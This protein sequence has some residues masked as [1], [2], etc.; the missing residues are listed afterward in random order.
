MDDRFKK[1]LR[2]C[3]QV[4]PFRVRAKMK[5]DVLT[6]SIVEHLKTSNRVPFLVLATKINRVHKVRIDRT[7]YRKLIEN[8]MDLF[9][10][11]E[12]DQGDLFKAVALRH[13]EIPSF[14]DSFSK[15][16]QEECSSPSAASISQRKAKA[17]QTNADTK[18]DISHVEGKD[19]ENKL[20]D[21]SEVEG[22]YVQY[23]DASTLLSAEVAQ[24]QQLISN[25]ENNVNTFI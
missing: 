11:M 20:I 18:E 10:T 19:Y 12:W 13:D 4:E 6:T 17:M 16:K 5:V 3:K 22:P 21:E 14:A 7:K 23:F 24:I 8:R 15:C 2:D 25:Y 1:G 9:K